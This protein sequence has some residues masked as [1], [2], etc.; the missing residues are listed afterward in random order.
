MSAPVF[1][2]L[3]AFLAWFS[4][5]SQTARRLADASF[6]I[7]LAHLP[8]VVATQIALAGLSVGH[9]AHLGW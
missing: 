6:W 1:G 7:Y 8:V 5:P 9:P 4:H 3:G 2:W